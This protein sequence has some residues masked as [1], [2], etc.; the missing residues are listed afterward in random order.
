M[1]IKT[2]T[3][4]TVLRNRPLIFL[5]LEATGLEI[6]KQEILEIGALKVNSERPF[7]VIAELSLKVKPKNIKAADKDALKI[8]GYKESAW[9]KALDLAEALKIL[10]QFAETG[11]LVGFNTCFDWAMLDKAYF[12]LGRQDPFYYHRLDVMTMAYFKLF[13]NPEIKRFSLGEVTEFYKIER[14]NIHQALDDAKAT[15]EVFKKLMSD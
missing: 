13:S 12:G 5:D 11:V 10:D 2:D 9:E 15:Y 8:V 3:H 6:Q 7:S 4:K 14:V 1:D